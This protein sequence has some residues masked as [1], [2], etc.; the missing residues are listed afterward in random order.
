MKI[1]LGRDL[2]SV[3]D[4]LYL[5]FCSLFMCL[6]S[7][8]WGTP[9]DLEIKLDSR[10]Y[11]LRDT[12]TADIWVYPGSSDIQSLSLYLSYHTESLRLLTWNVDPNEEIDLLLVEDHNESRGIAGFEGGFLSPQT[13]SLHLLRLSFQVLQASD[14]S[15]IGFY[16][17]EQGQGTEV[18]NSS[19]E[20][21]I[22]IAAFEPLLL[23]ISCP[24]EPA[25]AGP[26]QFICR[27]TAQ[28][29][30]RL[31]E[32]YQGNWVLVSGEGGS[33]T[34]TSN[35]SSF[36]VG[37]TGETYILSWNIDGY[38]CASASDTVKITFDRRPNS[39]NAGRNQVVF[40]DLTY[41][42]AVP[43]SFFSEGSWRLLTEDS[44]AIIRDPEDPKSG[45]IGRVGHTYLLEWSELRQVCPV[46]PDTVSVSFKQI[47]KAHAGEDQV[48]V[49]EH[50]TQLRA[51][52]PD[53]NLVGAWK[54]ISGGIGTF[55]DRTSPQATFRGRL[56][57]TYTL[58]WTLNYQGALIDQD[59]VSISFNTES[60]DMPRNGRIGLLNPPRFRYLLRH[61]LFNPLLLYNLP[62][63][64]WGNLPQKDNHLFPSRDFDRSTSSIGVDAVSATETYYSHR[65]SSPET[66]PNSTTRIDFF[67]NPVLNK[68]LS[69][70]ISGE[71]TN[72]FSFKIFNSIGQELLQGK[73]ETLGTHEVELNNFTPGTYTLIAIG[74]EGQKYIE[75]IFVK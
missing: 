58:E 61:G 48:I 23:D 33:F 29:E 37:R 75:K 9:G 67:P 72:N 32:S 56:G 35:P 7:Q 31:P 20:S 65:I 47:P 34:D 71:K 12:F 30:A 11:S 49:N 50:E 6:A 26:D 55:S 4:L 73:W 24:E 8:V 36:F 51:N 59:T 52:M 68:R 1:Q 14:S 38:T 41:L 74:H 27:N 2:A 62:E 5:F 60:R 63:Q 22:D 69:V 46:N 45:F 39:L 53:D 13:D 42:D 3:K 64:F 54:I 25:Q 10:T 15:F 70:Y 44:F 17:S 43:S 57:L 66:F 18:L 21:I 28:L 40:G 16:F 19:T